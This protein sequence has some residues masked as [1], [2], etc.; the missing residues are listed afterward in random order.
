RIGQGIEFDYCCVHGS[1]ALK[2]LDYET[3]MVNCN[4]ETVS[5]DY[6]TSDRLYFEPLTFEDVMNIVDREQPYGAIIQFGGQTPLKLAKELEK[7][8]V[9]ILGTSPES[10]D[11]AEDRKRFGQILKKLDI[12]QAANG[13]ARSFKEAVKVAEKVGYPVLVRPSYVLGGR[14]MELAYTE[15]ML[16]EYMASAVK[17][18]PEHPVL[19]D[20]FLE[21]AIE[22]DVDALSDGSQVVIGGIMEHIE[23]AGIHSGD[24]ACVI[25]PYTLSDE[26]VEVIKDYTTKLGFELNVI[27]LLNIQFAVKDETVYV[28]EVNPRASRTVPF[29]SKAIGVPLAK[30]AARIMVGESLDET[31][32]SIPERLGYMAIKE[33]V[34][35]FGRFPGSDTVL[36]PEM[37]STGE[38]MGLS[39]EFSVAY[40]KSQLAT[41]LEL[42]GEGRVFISVC[43]R[44]KRNSRF[45]AK[46]LADLGYELVSTKGTADLLRRAGIEVEEVAKVRERRP[47]VVDLIINN[48]VGL[49]IN[50]PWGKGT[51]SDGFD[52][53]TAAAI[54]GV[55]CVT[56]IAAASALVQ[57]LEAIRRG[58]LN[59]K[60]LQDYYVKPGDL[61]ATPVAANS[62]NRNSD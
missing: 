11:L 14:A 16:K 10:I 5:T 61:E 25:P 23:E 26:I 56:T 28:L 30:A 60:A 18:S 55:P 42:P 21:G 34:L 41:G 31:A 27:G 17:A 19:I 43:N 50:T 8:G 1:F 58:D 2:E 35:P 9:K 36:G 49:V 46:S 33:A 32:S 48:E 37:R 40:A 12:P 15:A 45:I 7:A 6:D 13:T 47:N 62:E 52:I 22:V 3:I 54:H 59:V 51:H 44:D 24:S 53:R 4:P 57:G 20:K 29:V 38:V 39:E